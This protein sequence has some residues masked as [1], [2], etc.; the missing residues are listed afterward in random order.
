MSN[1]HTQ[2]TSDGKLAKSGLPCRGMS[3]SLLSGCGASEGASSGS[4][5]A[6]PVGSVYSF[7]GGNNAYTEYYDAQSSPEADG[8]DIYVSGFDG[9]DGSHLTMRVSTDGSS[10]RT[11]ATGYSYGSRFMDGGNTNLN[12]N[13][14]DFRL[15]NITG[16]AGNE[17]VHGIIKLYN[18]HSSRIATAYTNISPGNHND[19]SSRVIYGGGHLQGETNTQYNRGF[20][21]Y[22]A[23][24]SPDAGKGR[25][26][27]SKRSA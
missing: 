26:F 25:G 22:S 8:I 14:S 6:E 20:S 12:N 11:D 15:Y 27:K 7:G 17:R 13:T 2:L 21:V 1:L 10:L 16:A 5:G 4:D 24:G 3:G 19:G 9:D 18:V 23:G